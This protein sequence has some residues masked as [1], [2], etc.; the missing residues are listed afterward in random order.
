[1]P[2]ARELEHPAEWVARVGPAPAAA[3]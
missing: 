2:S 3:A 1:L